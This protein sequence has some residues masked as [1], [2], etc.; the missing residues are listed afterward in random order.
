MKIAVLVVTAGLLAGQAPEQKKPTMT[1]EE[2]REKVRQTLNASGSAIDACVN[3]YISE[4]PKAWGEVSLALT[5]GKTGAV[6]KAKGSTKLPGARNLRSCLEK[7]GVRWMF[8]E[9]KDP[10]KSFTLNIPIAKGVKFYIRG[11]N[12]PPPPEP[13]PE[14]SGFLRFQPRFTGQRL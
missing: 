5:I 1:K 11:P 4:Q 14:P 3:R 10:G 6:K 8:P 9:P 12:D 13:Q 7:V 2:A